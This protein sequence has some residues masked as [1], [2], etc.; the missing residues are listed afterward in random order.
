MI[1]VSG[2][3]QENKGPADQKKLSKNQKKVQNWGRTNVRKNEEN[4]KN[5]Y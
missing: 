4:G 1:E 2:K 3:Y 5:Q